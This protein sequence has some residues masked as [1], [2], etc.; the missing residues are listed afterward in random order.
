[1]SAPVSP[2]LLVLN[3]HEDTMSFVD[4]ATLEPFDRIATGHNPHE[5]VLTPDRRFAYVSNYAPPGNTVSVIDTVRREHIAQIPTGAYTRIHGAAMAPDGRCAYFTAGQ[6][7]FVVEVDTATNAVARALPTQGGI[8]HMVL[9]TPDARRLVTAN[10]KTQDVSVLDRATGELVTRIPCGPG[11]E[12]IGFTPNGRCLWALNQEAGSITVID[13][14]TLEPIE[15][16]ACPGMP[17]RVRFTPDGAR[18]LVSS[19]AEHGELVVLDTATHVEMARLTVGRRAI[20]LELSP[21]ARR[22]FVGCEYDD[23]VHVVDLDTLTVT[24]R[25]FTGNGSDAIAWWEAP[26]AP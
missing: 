21:D 9:V 19:W 10:I 18:A 7:G 17:V 6:T 25:F 13:T 16:F 26:A 4:A 2:A 15:T 20:G 14:D 11:C 5:I 24:G 1:M 3:K 12:G 23:G 22:A 8:S